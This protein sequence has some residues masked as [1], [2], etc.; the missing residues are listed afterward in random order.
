MKHYAPKRCLTIKVSKSTICDDQIFPFN[1]LLSPICRPSS[2]FLPLNTF[3]DIAPSKLQGQNFQMAITL[4][5]IMIFSHDTVIIIIYKLIPIILS[6]ISH[7]QNFQRTISKKICCL[8]FNFARKFI[9]SSY[10]VL[11]KIK[12]HIFL[13]SLRNCLSVKF[14]ISK[15]KFPGEMLEKNEM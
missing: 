9:Y 1:I 7:L 4:N 14:I 11:A 6:E 15:R 13:V 12:K 10:T 8:F 2:K 3:R 5:K